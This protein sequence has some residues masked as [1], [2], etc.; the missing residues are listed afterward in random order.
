MTY[1]ILQ[2]LVCLLIAA[3]IGLVLGWLLRG[4]LSD[5]AQALKGTVADLTARLA[6]SEKAAADAAQG[7]ERLNAKLAA[8][9]RDASEARQSLGDLR[10]KL[11]AADKGTS[12]VRSQFLNL[13]GTLQTVQGDL[14][15]KITEAEAAKAA[16]LL[17]VER[18]RAPAAKAGELQTAMTLLQT[19]AQAQAASADT[20][21]KARLARAE[22]ETLEAR[23]GLAKA[24]AEIAR[25]AA[26]IR[27]GDQADG[28]TTLRFAQAETDWKM[29]LANAERQTAAVQDDLQRQRARAQA[30]ESELA[31]CGAARQ[32][33]TA[34]LE[35]AKRPAAGPAAPLGFA[36]APMPAAAE[37]DDLKD[38]VGIGPVLERQLHAAGIRTF[39]ALARLTPHE[40]NE[41]AEKLEHVFGTRITRERW[42]EQAADLHRRKYGREA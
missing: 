20:A 41:L 28:A 9:E 35:A 37:A 14:L 16:A 26:S 19:D 24:E 39:A 13:Q 11:E 10:G 33:L 38:I 36:T 12:E 1:L 4:W 32:A 3:A 25:L 27:E 5:N 34:E 23:T 31:A 7:T 15:R 17:E 22:A 8:S 42:V 2:I 40:V 21:W 6:T 29:R 18:L 30:L